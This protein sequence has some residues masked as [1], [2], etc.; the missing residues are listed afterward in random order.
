MWLQFSEG[1]R[2][3]HDYGRNMDDKDKFPSRHIISLMDCKHKK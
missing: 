3:W 2:V 1:L